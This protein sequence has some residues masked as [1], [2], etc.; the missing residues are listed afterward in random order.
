[1]IESGCEEHT[2]AEELRRE[3]ERRKT[4]TKRERTAIEIIYVTN[5]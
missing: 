4:K 5:D 1:M 3:E 2:V